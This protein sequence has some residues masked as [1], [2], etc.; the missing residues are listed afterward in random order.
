LKPRALV[1]AVLAV[2]ASGGAPLLLGRG[3]A[4]EPSLHGIANTALRFT[5]ETREFGTIWTGESVTREFAFE[6]PTAAPIRILDVAP[7][8]GCVTVE[9]PVRYVEPGARGT[10]RATFASEAPLTRSEP[11]TTRSVPSRNVRRATS[12]SPFAE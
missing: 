11:R 5:P 7:T 8:C 1:F 3:G 10:I 9:A 12:P 6:N 4:L 2:A